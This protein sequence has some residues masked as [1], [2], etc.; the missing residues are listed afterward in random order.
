MEPTVISDRPTISEY[1]D[2]ADFVRDMLQF[3]KSRDRRFSVQRATR[4]LRR[5]SPA[6]VSLVVQK[7]RK[8]T[9]DRVDE[10]A[11]LLDLNVTERYH[12]RNWIDRL[13]G[14]TVTLAES[15]RG[16]GNRKVTGTSLLSDWVNVYVKDLFHLDSVQRNPQLVEKMMA[17]V[18][19][20]QRV[21]K[22]LEFLLREGHLRRG[23]DGRLVIETNLTVTDP[24]TPN[25]KVRQF[26]KSTLGLAQRA[27]DIYSIE[28]R[29]ANALLIPLNEARYQELLEMFKEFAEKLQRFTADETPNPDR[30]YQVLINL[31]PVGKKVE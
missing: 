24:G 14:K 25:K 1:L 4:S 20:P 21:R 31:S 16:E 3:R 13:E 11:R 10:F 23:L 26:H 19:P 15:A 2:P 6:L 7:K 30:L 18:A 27:L 28:E 8:L 29:L 22:A 9:L 17:S 12:L 5:I